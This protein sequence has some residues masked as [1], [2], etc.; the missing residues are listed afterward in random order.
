MKW[1]VNWLYLIYHHFWTNKT[2]FR[3]LFLQFLWFFSD[4]YYKSFNCLFLDIWWSLTGFWLYFYL[5]DS[6]YC[7]SQP[8]L[9]F[10]KYFRHLLNV[11][12]GCYPKVS[13][14][15]TFIVFYFYYWTVHVLFYDINDFFCRNTYILFRIIKIEPRLLFKFY[16]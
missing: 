3:Q 9:C 4:N 11:W 13:V 6:Y 14:S 2:L 15:I 16:F 12:N 7:S 5:S 10:I 1:D 8:L